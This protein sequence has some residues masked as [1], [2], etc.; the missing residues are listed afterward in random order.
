MPLSFQLLVDPVQSC[1]QDNRCMTRQR[2]SPSTLLAEKASQLEVWVSKYES[3][4]SM[5]SRCKVLAWLQQ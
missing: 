1:L 2:F 3:R 5:N 4:K